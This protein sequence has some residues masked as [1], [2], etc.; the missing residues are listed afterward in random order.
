MV[1]TVGNVE[2]YIEADKKAPGAIGRCM[3]YR[4]ETTKAGKTYQAGDVIRSEGTYNQATLTAMYTALRRIR[5]SCEITIHIDNTYIASMI[6]K[7]LLRWS[8]RDFMTGNGEE[9]KNRAEWKQ[10]YE[11]FRKYRVTIKPGQH[12]RSALMRKEIEKWKQS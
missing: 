7:Y 10:L 4:L 3:A 11:E 5:Q 8:M 6:D 1:K 2:I 12:C 9:I